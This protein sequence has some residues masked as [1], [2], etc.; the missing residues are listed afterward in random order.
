MSEQQTILTHV[1][2]PSSLLGDGFLES[3]HRLTE[4]M[5]VPAQ[6][7]QDIV[8]QIRLPYR[9]L[10]RAMETVQTQMQI[11]SPAMSETFRQ[12]QRFQEMRDV[13][14]K[15]STFTLPQSTTTIPAPVRKAPI[16]YIPYDDALE[17]RIAM[18]VVE[19]LE[20]KPSAEIELC[21]DMKHGELLDFSPERI[22]HVFS[23]REAGRIKI[24]ERLIDHGTFAK[25][26][27]LSQYSEYKTEDSLR[28]A[29]RAINTFIEHE[30][31][32]PQK[33]I[34]GARGRGYRINPRYKITIRH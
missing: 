5:V 28:K 25:T 32:L 31:G 26:A 4:Q 23:N 17:E 20:S 13:F 14:L 19:R 7:M 3:L 11:V 18:R 29:M 22:S 9:E 12:M 10:Q 6:R 15:Q 27:T 34:L 8:D 1:Q 16:H 2:L 24:L 30:M 33:L 21:L